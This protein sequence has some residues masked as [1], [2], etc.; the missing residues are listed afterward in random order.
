MFKFI[1]FGMG[2]VF[3]FEGL[4]FFFFSNKIKEMYKFINSFNTD[5]IKSFSTFLILLGIG[6]IYFTFR[7]YEFE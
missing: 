2:F 5:K 6:L 4:V 1:L 3:L 7:F